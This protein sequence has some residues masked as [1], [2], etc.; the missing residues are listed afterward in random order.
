M[1]VTSKPGRPEAL[2]TVSIKESWRDVWFCLRKPL[3]LEISA[4]AASMAGLEVRYWQLSAVQDR[5]PSWFLPRWLDRGHVVL[6]YRSGKEEHQRSFVLRGAARAQAR[7]DILQ[8]AHR[9]LTRALDA[10]DRALVPIRSDIER[11][12]RSD[13]YVRHS[14]AARITSNHADMGRKVAPVL[15]ALHRHPLLAPSDRELARSL[16]DELA[17]LAKRVN[18][19]EASRTEHNEQYLAYQIEA[20]A[21]YFNAVESSPLTPEQTAAALVFEDATL[22][23]AAAGSGKSSCI[24]GKIG[25]ALKSGLFQDHEILALAYNRKAA[26][27]LDERLSKKLSKAIGRK[28]AVASK[29]FHSFGLSVM[30]EANGEGIRPRVLKEEA[31]EEGR[32]LRTVIDR[33]KDED[34]PFQQALAD[35]LLFAPFEDPSPSGIAGNLEDCEKRYEECCRQRIKAKREEGKKSYEPSIPTLDP[36]IHVRSLEE[37]SIV[38]W[39]FLRGIP[40][41]YETPDWDGAKLLGLGVSESTKKQR[42]YKPDF[43]YCQTQQLSNGTQ[44]EVRVIHEHF[45]LDR[46]GRAPAWMGGAEYEAQARRKRAMFKKRVAGGHRTGKPV[47]FFETTSA[48]MRDGTLWNHLEHSLKAAGIAVGPRSQDVYRRAIASFGPIE[49]LEQLIMDFVLRFKDS[50][51]TEG[52]VLQEAKQQPNSWRALLFL[53]VA[54]PVFHAYQQALRDAGKI[55]YADMLREALAALRDGRVKTPYRFVLVDEFQ[56]IARLRADLVKS[57]LD[58]APDESMVFCVGD[59]WQTINRFSGSDVSIFKN[60]G[61]H[62]GRHER[63]LMLSRTFRCSSG[64]ATLARE[65]VLKNDNQFDKPVQARPDRLSHCVRV[66][67]HKPGAEHRMPAL[68]TQLAALIET[69]K[70]LGIALPS[71]QILTRTTAET[72][73]PQ[74]LD[75]KDAI[76]ALKAR[77][78]GQLE[79]EVMS[80]HGSKG[81]EADFVVLVGFDSG[82]RGFPD[83]RAPEP[84]LD[85]VLPKLSHENEEER[86]LLYVGLTRAKHQ[87]IVLANGE[88]PS[89]YVLELSALSEHHAFIDWINLGAQRTDCP[90]CKVGSLQPPRNSELKLVCSRSAR[91]GYRGQ[92]PR[93]QAPTVNS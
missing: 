92:I 77:Y 81:L 51:L 41:G 16:K 58:Q 67:L 73:A 2:P 78:N 21:D 56:D 34:L 79:V 55:D 31:G 18:K 85:L 14:Q 83:E 8:R 61:N 35:W 57:V 44:R 54:F 63:H 10:A 24:V 9:E 66:V 88:A 60:I 30:V 11:T 4:K 59:D 6:T 86:R 42:P 62:F 22:V 37:R 64:I 75:S 7:K 82:F 32:F 69:G 89:E 52:E 50:G 40:V 91:C 93:R 12:Y 45:A 71:V 19:P 48:Q 39:L 3:S 23:V 46:N 47:V 27:S 25:F 84:L 1:E 15:D 72:T 38:N 80:L 36:A 17:D 70:D 53:K 5:A 26:K 65:L 74:G 20:E 87:V 33:L 68:E 76:D 13:R 49:G 43:T 90:R 28:V 29:T